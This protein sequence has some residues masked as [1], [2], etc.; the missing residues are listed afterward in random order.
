VLIENRKIRIGI[1]VS[2]IANLGP[3]LV[4]Q[5]LINAL[6]DDKTFSIRVFY[7]DSKVDPNVRL[8]VNPEQINR[9]KFRFTDFDIIHTNGIRPDLFAYLNRRKIKYHISTIHNYVFADLAFSY[10]LFVSWIF[11]NLWLFL[12]GHADKLVCVSKSLKSFYS[13]WISSSKLEVIYDGISAVEDSIQPDNEIIKSINSIHERGLKIVG[14]ASILT[15]RKG[16]AQVLK[17]VANDKELALV[18]F[19]DG[20]DLKKLN[21]L[22]EELEIT[23]RCFFYGFTSNAKFYFKYLDV[24]VMPSRSEGFGLALMEAVAQEIPVVCSDIEV[25]T[26]LFNKEEVTFFKLDNLS[27]LSGALKK[28][29][30]NGKQKAELAYT[31]YMNCYTTQLMAEHYTDLYKSACRL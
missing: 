12:W 14:C 10:N 2:R 1:I 4:M 18:I 25:F 3:V 5:N 16:I 26:E 30:E 22:S 8:S 27:S 28:A 24:F 13:K 31:K 17:V 7:M 29:L 11:G 9:G 6:V 21:R 20:K 19:G 15:K 23:S